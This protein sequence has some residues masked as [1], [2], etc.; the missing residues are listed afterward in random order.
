MRGVLLITLLLFI[1][2]LQAQTFVPGSFINNNYRGNFYNPVTM[3]DSTGQRKWS[4]TKYSGIST[5]ITFFKGGSATFF[6]VPLALQLNRRLKNNLFAF[7]GVSVAPSYVNFNQ[8]FLAGNFSKAS[9]NNPFF[10]SSNA[11]LY[12]RAELGLQYVNDE[13]TFSISASLGIEKSS[14]ALPY[15]TP[16]NI[17]NS[18]PVYT[19]ADNR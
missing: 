11:G 18:N 2:G 15:Y 17:K 5:G 4:V 3:K 16:S 13:R 12:S 19:H 14:Y 8:S 7:A 9:V 1:T 6:S 10:N